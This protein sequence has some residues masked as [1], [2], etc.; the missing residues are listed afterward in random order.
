M[1]E[2]GGMHEREVRCVLVGKRKVTRPRCKWNDIFEINLKEIGRAGVDWAHLAE[3][4]DEW[5]ALVTT[6]INLD[7]L[8]TM[9]AVS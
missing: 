9:L 3:G 6:K 1:D 7:V 5:R 8:Y 4:R 2:I